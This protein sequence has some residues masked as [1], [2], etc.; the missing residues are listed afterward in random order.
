M[1]KIIHTEVS[2]RHTINEIQNKLLYLAYEELL[3]LRGFLVDCYGNFSLDE[4][5]LEKYCEKSKPQWEKE[6]Q[7]WE[8]EF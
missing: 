7:K 8:K 5:S 6:F 2:D 1:E 4:E 3:E